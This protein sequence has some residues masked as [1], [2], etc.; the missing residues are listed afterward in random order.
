MKNTSILAHESIK[1]AKE[2]LHSKILSGLKK[3]EKGTFREIA[4]AS[5]LD[6]Q[7]VWKRLSEMERKGMI[8]YTEEKKQCEVSHRLCGIWKINE[9]V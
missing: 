5:N 1:P 9:R 3:I 8:T 2:I 4:H 7:Q 6:E